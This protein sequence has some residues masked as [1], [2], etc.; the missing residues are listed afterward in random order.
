MVQQSEKFKMAF[1]SH[2]NG[3][4]T[5]AC[6]LYKEILKIEPE[7]HEVLD[8]LGVLYCQVGKFCES[9]ECIK[10]A[11]ELKPLLYYYENLA[12]LYL[13]K[14]DF[15]KA[16]NCYEDIISGG[17]D[18]YEN[19]FNLA[20]AYKNNNNFLKAEEYYKK[21]LELKPE[22]HEVY[23]NLA[24]LY[25]AQINPQKAIICYKKA[26]ELKPD[27]WESDYF[28]SL[29]YMQSKDYKNGLKSFESRLCRQSAIL[30]QY[31]TYPKLIEEKKIWQGEDLRDKVLYTYYEAGFGD[32]L[33]FY[34]FMPELVSKCKKV[35]FK[36]QKELV[37]LLRENSY[38]AEIMDLFKPE[39]EFDFDFH[40]PFL[41]VPYVLGK[42][43]QSMFIHHDDG[44]LNAD[45]NKVQLFKE[46]FFDNRK[47]KIGIKWQG[48]TF[49]EK[50][51]VLKVEDFFSLFE[52]ENTQFY[53]CQTYEGSEEFSK[54][55]EKYN[56]INLAPEFNDFSD[57]AAAIENLDLIIC[58]DTSLVHLA[59]AMK[60]KC[61]VL[62]P[63]LYNWR[64]HT[65]LNICDWYDSV[66]LFRQDKPDSWQ[67]VF[68]IVKKELEKL[69]F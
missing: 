38:G 35:I 67:K 52:L 44:Y 27:D 15:C 37:P 32:I 48:N 18:T 12:R 7:N 26:I 47:F 30:S 46:K 66:K 22:S 9:E 53:S 4:L 58:N 23:F 65:D 56:V 55:Q 24:A 10:K 36:P 11:I 14:C 33:M 60:K 54:I 1:E 43:A 61:F 20:M 59:G 51:R 29:A 42:S 64:W 6:D 21:A 8:L 31:K 19:R 2:R 62:L 45:F 3:Q 69:V 34:R 57:T 49:Y 39:N 50:N 63:Y 25:L 16:I 17:G 13:Q 41:S 5:R 68:D 28:L 40:I